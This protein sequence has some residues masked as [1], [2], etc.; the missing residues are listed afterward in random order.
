MSHASAA[1]GDPQFLDAFLVGGDQVCNGEGSIVLLGI[2][3][4]R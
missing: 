3:D 1:D 2:S 4:G